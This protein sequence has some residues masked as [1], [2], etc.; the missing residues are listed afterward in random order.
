MIG[1]L[2]GPSDHNEVAQRIDI[3]IRS[4]IASRNL[5]IVPINAMRRIF[6][7][8]VRR[9]FFRARSNAR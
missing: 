9:K 4:G 8:S 6:S 3:T 2:V 1:K 7:P 5:P